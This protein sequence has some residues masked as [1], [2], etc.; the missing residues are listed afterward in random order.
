ML[1]HSYGSGFKGSKNIY[2]TAGKS[3]SRPLRASSSHGTFLM[4]ALLG[5]LFSP[6]AAVCN[7]LILYHIT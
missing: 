5:F 6:P 7:E 2:I 4:A 3:T 1:V